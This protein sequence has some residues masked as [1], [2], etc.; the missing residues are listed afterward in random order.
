MWIAGYN[1]AGLCHYGTA[2]EMIIRRIFFYDNGAG[3]LLNAVKEREDF[4]V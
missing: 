4:L 2:N 1:D 3:L